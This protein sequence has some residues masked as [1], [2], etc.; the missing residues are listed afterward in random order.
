M[1]SPY[2]ALIGDF[3]NFSNNGRVNYLFSNCNM[4]GPICRTKILIIV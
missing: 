2:K 1:F 3:L 4:G